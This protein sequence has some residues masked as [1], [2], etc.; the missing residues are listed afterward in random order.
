MRGKAKGTYETLGDLFAS[1]SDTLRPP[2]RLRV[3][4]AAT[5][6]LRMNRLGGV[7]KYSLDKT[8]YMAEPMDTVASP[9]YDAVIFCGPAQSSK[10]ESL[11]M[12]SIAYSVTVNPLDM[13]LVNPTQQNARDFS[14]L[15]I[16]KMHRDSPDI[17][18]LVLKRRDA[19]SKSMKMYRNG[20]LLFLSW[21][22]ISELSGKPIPRMLLTDY[23]RMPDDIEGDGAPFDLARKRTTTFGSYA[24]TVAESSPSRPQTTRTWIRRTPHEAPPTAGGIMALYN[25]GDRRRLYWPCP[26]CNGYFEGTF[27]HL[28]WDEHESAVECAETVRL[29]CSLCGEKI[30][31]DARDEMLQFSQWVRDGQQIE[32]GGELTGSPIRSRLAS[33]WLRGVA[34][35]LS[36]W[37]TLV[38]K[39]VEAKRNYERTG[40]EKPLQTFFNTDLAE[41]Y[42]PRAQEVERLPEILKARAEELPEK[43]VPEGVRFLIGTVDVQKNMFVVRIFGIL[44]G[45]PFDMVLIDAFDIRKSERVD[46]GGD[47]LWVKPATYL[48]DWDVLIDGVLKKTYP[49]GDQSGRRMMIRMTGCDSGGYAKEKLHREGVTTMAYAFQRK[50]K[51][52]GLSGRFHLVKGD[53]RAD[54][55]RSGISYPDAQ[56]KDRLAAA[57]GDVPVLLLNSNRLKDDL[58]ARLECQ[59]PGTGMY[60]FPNWL[61]DS[62][63]T[64]LCA[65]TR[66]PSGWENKAGGRNET[67]DLSYYCIGLC[68]SSLIRVDG[69]DWAKPPGWA[70]EWD[71]SDLVIKPGAEERF[72]VKPGARYDTSSFAALGAALA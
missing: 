59:V 66:G 65:E 42:V 58:S 52:R 29:V 46:E 4:E 34:A 51:E 72:A 23:D 67:W 39:Y 19:D 26:H 38:Q 48:D 47:R 15:R 3:S 30:Y 27:D 44:P 54:A 60:R 37:Q 9:H 63:Y 68:V 45:M 40:D 7:E 70:A 50:L 5:R 24:M 11:I 6:S 57:R 71:K 20:M 62:V 69:I 22:T 8:P 49:L 43:E 18:K 2:E 16:D 61:P 36:S 53:P 31:P 12:G 14:V 13:M 10:T 56:R 32:I 28:E 55:P 35:G 33:F 64:E 21:P 25:R 41:V 1:L 17:G